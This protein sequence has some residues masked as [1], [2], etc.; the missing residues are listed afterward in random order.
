MLVEGPGGIIHRVN[1]ER[2]D[3]GDVGGLERPLG[4]QREPEVE[5]GG[6]YGSI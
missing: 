5:L 6:S 3:A 4:L 2:P 1:R